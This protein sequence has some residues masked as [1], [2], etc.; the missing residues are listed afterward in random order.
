[1]AAN[2][3]TSASRRSLALTFRDGLW[4]IVLGSFFVLLAIQQPLEDRGFEIWASYMPALV[5]M[6]LGIPVYSWLK[7]KLVTPRI[8][9]VK[10]GLRTNQTR[11]WMLGLVLVFQLITLGIFLLSF[12]GRLGDFISSDSIWVID[13][14]FSLTI[15]GFFA[16]LAFTMDTIRFYLYGFLLG[17]SPLMNV[18]FSTDKIISNIPTFAAGLT[19]IVIG[20]VTFVS[21]LKNYSPIE[22]EIANG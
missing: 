1:M 17:L 22:Q 3:V 10:I 8:G 9:L 12:S 2:Q 19:M 14:F 20:V 6:A 11:R 21:F 4:D 5:A 15:F 13:V 7:K 16:F 18:L